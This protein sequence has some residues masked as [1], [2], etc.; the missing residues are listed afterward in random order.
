MYF[1]CFDIF[2]NNLMFGDRCSFSLISCGPKREIEKLRDV[3]EGNGISQTDIKLS[4]LDR[5]TIHENCGPAK[6]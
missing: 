6:E 4:G 5:L 2:E 1:I 3:E